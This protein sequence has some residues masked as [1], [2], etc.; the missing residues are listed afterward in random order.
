MDGAAAVR[1]LV[2]T[3]IVD[4]VFF[5]RVHPTAVM[6]ALLADELVAVISPWLE[7]QTEFRR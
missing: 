7:R 4:E 2:G 1:K 5:D 6:T 3:H